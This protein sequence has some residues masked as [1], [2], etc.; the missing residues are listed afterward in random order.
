MVIEEGSVRSSVIP[1]L[2]TRRW[3]CCLFASSYS[4]LLMRVLLWCDAIYGEDRRVFVHRVCVGTP[5][6]LIV[7]TA[8]SSEGVRRLALSAAASDGRYCPCVL[9]LSAPDLEEMVDIVGFQGKRRC[10]SMLCWFRA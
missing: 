3:R 1:I 8:D 6:R 2:E 9:T 10:L 5:M 4:V 7:P